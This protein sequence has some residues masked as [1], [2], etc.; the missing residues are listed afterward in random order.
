MYGE[1]KMYRYAKLI[2]A[3]LLT[4]GLS[5]SILMGS[6]T[7]ARADGNGALAGALIGGAIGAIASHD[8][9]RGALI[10]AVAG[11]IIGNAASSD[12]GNGRWNHYHYDNYGYDRGYGYYGGYND[13]GHGHDRGYHR[14]WR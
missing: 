8:S 1:N 10:G 4:V 3:A 9:T 13:Y 7:P 6:V 14:D 2:P 12:C 5:A 11:G